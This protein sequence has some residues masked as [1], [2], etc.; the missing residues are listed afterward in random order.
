MPH[1]YACTVLDEMRVAVKVGRIDMVSGLIEEL[2]TLVNRMEA[3]L[4]EYKD[5]GY[6]LKQHHK[7]R[8]E[9]A[10]MEDITGTDEFSESDEFRT[11]AEDTEQPLYPGDNC[12]P[13]RD[14]PMALMDKSVVEPLV[15]ALTAFNK[16]YSDSEPA[17]DKAPIQPS[18]HNPL[19]LPEHEPLAWPNLHCPADLEGKHSAIVFEN[20]SMGCRK[21]GLA[22][23]PM[24][25]PNSEDLVK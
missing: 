22:K 15:K 20:G 12:V 14:N 4:H 5:M 11:S 16:Q 13:V 18:L 9:I 3:G 10:A 21:C 1:R 6:D 2:Q 17:E 24:E 19:A 7:L 25:S 23:K 8:K